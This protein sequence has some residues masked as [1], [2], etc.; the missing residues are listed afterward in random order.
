MR[1]ELA[2]LGFQPGKLITL[3]F[4]LTGN[5]QTLGRAP[6]AAAKQEFFKATG[7]IEP[8]FGLVYGLSQIADLLAEFRDAAAGAAA[9]AGFLNKAA[10]KVETDRAAC[11]PSVVLAAGLLVILVWAL[12]LITGIRLSL[13]WRAAWRRIV[14]R[15]PR[16]LETLGRGPI[17]N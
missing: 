8:A 17:H 12:V 11:R 14:V 7:T 6:K 5:P 3:A 2:Q 4:T 1:V 13:W 16:P 9:V 15:F 10:L